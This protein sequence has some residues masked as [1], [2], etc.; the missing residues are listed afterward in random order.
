MS[1]KV[2]SLGLQL[3][4]GGG[5]WLGG[6]PALQSLL[7]ALDL[8]LGLRMARMAILLRDAE[9]GEQVLKAVAVG[10]EMILLVSWTDE[11]PAF[12]V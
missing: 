12:G 10:W 6:E 7:E 5:G 4:D 9:A 11:K 3:G 2:F 8:A 1:V